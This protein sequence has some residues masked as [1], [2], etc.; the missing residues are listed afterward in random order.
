MAS[1]PTR[2]YPPPPNPYTRP[3]HPT[4]GSLVCM[5]NWNPWRGCPAVFFCDGQHGPLSK[6]ERAH[7]TYW[8]VNTDGS[9]DLLLHSP[10]ISGVY[11]GPTC[12]RVWVC[13]RLIHSTELN[14]FSRSPFPLRETE[15]RG[16]VTP[17]RHRESVPAPLMAHICQEVVRSV[18]RGAAARKSLG[19]TPL[20]PPVKAHSVSLRGASVLLL[21]RGQRLLNFTSLS[22]CYGAEWAATELQGDGEWGSAAA[23]PIKPIRGAV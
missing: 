17:C 23:D 11:L 1:T 12:V 6:R 2:L 10:V 21:L 22:L 13:F 4:P 5:L 15:G 14:S 18:L 8:T 20:F 9:A 19:F 16:G 7:S 3:P